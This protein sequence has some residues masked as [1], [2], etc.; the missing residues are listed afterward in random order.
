MDQAKVNYDGAVIVNAQADGNCV[1]PDAAKSKP[2]GDWADGME[3]RKSRKGEILS[4][5]EQL[6]LVLIQRSTLLLPTQS[7]Q[8]VRLIAN[9]HTIKT[10]NSVHSGGNSVNATQFGLG[11]KTKGISEGDL[12]YKTQGFLT[13]SIDLGVKTKDNFH[14]VNPDILDRNVKE[15]SVI[16]KPKYEVSKSKGNSNDKN[17]KTKG[18]Y[19]I[20][21]VYKIAFNYNCIKLHLITIVYN[22]I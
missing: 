12:S 14:I 9:N 11:G 8:V 13:F 3:I 20:W 6:I 16:V 18:N 15:K 22:C 5:R 7:N 2:K 17:S 4:V 1:K 10:I 19:L 21:I